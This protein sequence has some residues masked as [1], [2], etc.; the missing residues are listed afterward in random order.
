VVEGFVDRVRQWWSSIIS[1]LYE[2]HFS[3]QI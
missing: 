3:S 2:L 1:R